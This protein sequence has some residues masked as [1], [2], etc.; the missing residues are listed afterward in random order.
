MLLG[1]YF[2]DQ[3]RFA[4]GVLV[5]TVMIDD[6]LANEGGME[7]LYDLV[8]YGEWNY[9]T[10][11][12]IAEWGY[13]EDGA[14]SIMGVIGDYSWTAR[15]FFASSGLDIFKTVN[16]KPEYIAA[17]GAEVFAIHNWLDELVTMQQQEF[18]ETDW[19]NN[20]ELNT[21]RA[22]PAES[23]IQGRSV[24]AINQMILSFEGSNIQSMRDPASIL[25]TPMYGEMFKT[26]ADGNYLEDEEDNLIPDYRAL[27]SDNAGSGGILISSN[28]AKFSVATAFLQLM[29]EQSA[30]F[31]EQY[32][33]FGL[34]LR[35]NSSGSM[36]HVDMLDYIHD[37]ICSPMSFLYD[38]YCAK[39][40]GHEDIRTY[41]YHMNDIIKSGTN[42]FASSW[43]AQHTAVSNRW[44]QIK[45]YYGR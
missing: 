38:N 33:E 11:L 27:T 24:F 18:V 37:G 28:Y 23:F 2:I 40:I 41:G 39:S 36:G 5:N 4:F 8:R 10:M 45:A 12:E 13:V 34:K 15:T 25:P 30:D 26:D 14:E 7:Y 6:I 17:D 16:G 3:F 43:K 35:D 44:A 20:R 21:S 32:Y 9:D 19:A 42:T 22:T 31:F 29:T 1:D